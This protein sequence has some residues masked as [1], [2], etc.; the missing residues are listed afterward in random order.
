MKPVNGRKFGRALVWMR[1]ALRVADNSVLWHA[2][3]DGYEVFP[4]VC[5][6]DAGIAGEES[7]RSRF[8]KAAVADLDGNLRGKGSA[9]FFVEGDPLRQIPR[10]AVALG[11]GAVYV[12]EPAG[13]DETGD[14]A[15]LRS[16]LAAIGCALIAIPDA[17][18]TGKD[19]VLT[20]AGTP[21]TVFTPYRRAWLSNLDVA[22]P[23]FPVSI[24]PLRI[25]ENALIAP[26]R[27]RAPGVPGGETA[28]LRRLRDFMR[29]PVNEYRDRRDIPGVEGTSRLSPDIACGTIS[30]RT[31]LRAALEARAA[32][33]GG[34]I[35][36][37]V[38]CFIGELIWREFYHQILAHYPH[39]ASGPFRE[40][41]GRLRWSRNRRHFLAWCE[42]R[43][44]YPI[45]DA[46][47]RQLNAEGWMH[48]RVR[49]IAASFLTKDLHIDWRWGERY[50][51]ERLVDAD[52]A[53]NNGGWQWS[54]G[55]GTDAA[56]YFRVFNPV[57]QGNRFDPSGA[58]V[59]KYVPEVAGVPS[60]AVHAPWEMSAARA[61]ECSFRIGRDYPRPIVVHARE[62]EVTLELYGA[63][64]RGMKAHQPEKQ[65]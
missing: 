30:V 44:G 29:A 9:L 15:A 43:T 37:G 2:L 22:P 62:R 20:K 47:M 39:V 36:E 4:F 8:I 33:E 28:A 7:P 63:A 26:G 14:D 38:D 16:A 10:A 48:N 56:P 42:G 25:P 55:T 59:R 58:Y 35:T 3:R 50:F 32:A 53:S 5:P 27:F 23:A 21:Y 1:R 54:A 6:R 31:V 46:G 40:E 17:V 19:D 24:R 60:S 13:P 45:V 34:G 49:M 18:I 52:A 64:R 11:A 65:T 61:K 41:F 51:M 12:G 57:S